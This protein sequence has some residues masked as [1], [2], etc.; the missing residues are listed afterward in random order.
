MRRRDLLIGLGAAAAAPGN[1]GAQPSPWRVGFVHPGQSGAVAM[2]LVG[3][4]EGL[5]TS[6]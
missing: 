3:F 5:R 1:A 2:R 6:N 4:Q